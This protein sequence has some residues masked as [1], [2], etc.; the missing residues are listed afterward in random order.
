MRAKRRGSR[1][2]KCGALGG[3]GPRAASGDDE[4]ARERVAAVVWKISPPTL[5]V[6]TEVEA[7]VGLALTWKDCDEHLAREEELVEEIGRAHV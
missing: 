7:M 4:P 6:T 5:R 3:E 2:R 1:S